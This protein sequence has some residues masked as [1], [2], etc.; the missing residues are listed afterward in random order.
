MG[1]VD[2]VAFDAVFEQRHVEI[3]QEAEA[4]VG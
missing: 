1:E 3:D 4:F 2:H